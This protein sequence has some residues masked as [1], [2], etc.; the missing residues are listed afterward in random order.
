[1][2]VTFTSC[3][4]KG[5]DSKKVRLLP[6]QRTLPATSFHGSGRRDDDE[7]VGKQDDGHDTSTCVCVK[8]ATSK[9]HPCPRY[10][11]TR[12]LD[13]NDSILA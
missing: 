4:I 5:R 3:T 11:H 6:G 9:G 10:S 13:P 12:V 7:E 8:K 1:M 2:S